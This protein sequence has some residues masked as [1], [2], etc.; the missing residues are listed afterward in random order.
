MRFNKFAV[1]LPLLLLASNLFGAT[2]FTEFYC[3]STGTNINSGSTTGAI[4]YTS[5]NGAWSTVTGGFTPTDGTTPAS[6]VS[7][8]MWASVYIDAATVGVYIGRITN[9]AAG[10]NGVILV[11]QTTG[12][13]APPTTSATTRTIRIGGPWQGPNAA[14]GFPLTLANLLRL[15]NATPDRPRIN[16]KN[17]ANYEVSAAIA[18]GGVNIAIQ[19]YTTTPGD[20]GKATLSG[21][22]AVASFALLTL[23]GPLVYF[24]DFIISSNGTSSVANALTLSGNYQTIENVVVKGCRGSGFTPSGVGQ[25]FIGCEAYANSQNN[26]ATEAAFRM[27]SS[28]GTTYI[29][30]NAHDTTAANAS[31]WFITGVPTT[32]IDCIADSN[33]SNGVTIVTST[34]S[35]NLIGCEFYNN[36]G[37][38]VELKGTGA[39][40]TQLYVENCNFVKN[41]LW[42]LSS[43]ANGS[44]C[45]GVIQNCGFGSGTQA[46]GSGTITTTGWGGIYVRDTTFVTYS[47]NTTPWLDAPNGDFRISN[48]QAWGTGLGTFTE[49]QASYSGT[50]GYPDIGAAQHRG[51]TNA[52]AA[53]FAQ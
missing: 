26:G 43:L 39:S 30:C 10:A 29:R 53:A 50:I 5:T 25:T 8:G 20:G 51:V 7:S 22:A 9:V 42:G 12:A 27:A 31:G 37:Q 38:G 16:F 2:A 1:L 14:S 24:G 23:S 45:V 6:T 18:C 47:A 19:G 35:L 52:T 40:Q 28:S 36:G 32:L 33:G 48:N 4:T 34:S 41:A 13:G 17:T 21:N 46:N 11:D 49:T 15:T 44:N 3:M